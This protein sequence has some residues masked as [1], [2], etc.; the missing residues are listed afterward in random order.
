MAIPTGV[1]F[2]PELVPISEL[3]LRQSDVLDRLAESPVVLTQHGRAAAVLVNPAQ[4]AEIVERLEFLED[5]LEAAEVRARIHAG[6][7]AVSEWSEIEA[8][9]NALPDP[10]G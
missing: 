9:L 3:R 2:I 8:E 5:S 1:F 6:E 7:E 4:W 10:G